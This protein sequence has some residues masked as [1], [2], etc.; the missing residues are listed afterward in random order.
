LGFVIVLAK[1]AKITKLFF[2]LIPQ[3]NLFL[4]FCCIFHLENFETMSWDKLWLKANRVSYME[5]V[6]IYIFD[7]IFYLG[8]SV[9][10][11]SYKDSGLEF[12]DYINSF[13]M[14]VSRKT[15]TTDSHQ[16][17]NEF[18]KLSNP[19]FE[20][21]HQELSPINKQKLEQNNCLRIINV[22]KNFDEVQA[23][24]NFKGE[25]FSNEIFCLLGH[26][27]A[28]KTT[29]VNM[30]SGIYDPNQGD[31]LF[32]GRSLVTNKKYLY[33]NIGLCQQEDI[34][35][36]YLTVK[37]HLEYMCRIKGSKINKKEI[38]ELIKKIE[39]EPKK[40]A[41]C[42]TL[43]GGQK[44]KLC[45][46]LALIGG[47]QIILLDEPTSGMDVLAR[48]KLWEFLKVYKKDKILLITTHYLDEAEYLGDRIGIMSDGE[49]LCSGT[50]SFLKSKY[51][52]GFNLNFLINPE[53]FNDDNKER[54][55]DGIK[56]YDPK[57]EIRIASKGIFTI[58]IQ[59]YNKNIPE[60]FD[61]IEQKK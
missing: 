50:S 25:L 38:D 60:I 22:S 4:C 45:I 12:F 34:Y 14:N 8:L 5:S 36:D 44:R 51:P 48:R 31:I 2:S 54:F 39:L 28:G 19:K 42:S 16:Q 21:H 1:T 58:N 61:F 11:Q 37:E 10:I 30:I 33:E 49:Y 32:N 57:A 41:L 17:L 20:T 52:C 27:G 35:F 40:D 18:E 9:L 55:F 24:N 43:S 56:K 23:V 6:L 15:N 29:L 3:I 47:S 13:F 53:K 46:A 26:N 7:I 59:S